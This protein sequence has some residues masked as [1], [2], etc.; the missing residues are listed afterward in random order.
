[1]VANNMDAE[2]IVDDAP[3]L[4]A[5][6]DRKDVAKDGEQDVASLDAQLEALESRIL[7]SAR[8]NESDDGQADASLDESNLDKKK[9]DA[10]RRQLQEQ[11]DD[12][13]WVITELPVQITAPAYAALEAFQVKK[14]REILQLV[15]AFARYPMLQ[16][17]N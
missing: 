9:R 8:E 16:V 6:D 12:A 5:I 11:R 13:P 17:A 4:D 15:R 14:W 3:P 1:V 7:A 2:E 10:L